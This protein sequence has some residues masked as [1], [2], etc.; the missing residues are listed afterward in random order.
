MPMTYTERVVNS[1][2][3]FLIRL[4]FRVDQG[5]LDKIPLTGPGILAT[6][7]TT[8]LEAP[9]YYVLLDPRSKTAFGKL[10]LW[11]NPITRFLMQLWG[12][13][14]LRR[15][16]ADRVAMRR[17][18]RALDRGQFLGI[19]P[20]GT[21]SRTGRLKQGRPGMAMLAVERR[22]PIFPM[23]HWGISDVLRNL[24]RVRKTHLHIRVGTPFYLKAPTDRRV[25]AKD[26]RA[27]TD[28]IMF[29]LAA[30]LPESLR[31]YYHDL[32]KM[33]SY[34]IEPATEG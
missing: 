14:P 1:I 3:R 23:V 2:L 28:E 24:A 20:E 33:T 29:R 22:V 32:S 8:N 15:G 13:V 12:V 7:H 34:Y 5:E 16:S 27:M 31:G 26:I 6:N 25:T 10:E 17:A 30:L 4:I 9:I 21:R 11:H 19:A 18:L